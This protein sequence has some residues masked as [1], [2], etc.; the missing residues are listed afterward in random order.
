MTVR[1]DLIFE[2]TKAITVAAKVA[3]NDY[4][5]MASAAID[6]VAIYVYEELASNDLPAL[7]FRAADES[8]EPPDA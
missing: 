7:E 3:P 1:A 8:E 2:V 5:G 4:E 6:A